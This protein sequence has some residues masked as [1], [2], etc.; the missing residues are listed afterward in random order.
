MSMMNSL[1]AFIASLGAGQS[2][3][4]D[5]NSA[6]LELRPVIGLMSS[7]EDLR[8]L[9]SGVGATLSVL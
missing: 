7:V 5:P 9:L 2:A 3:H 4:C 1:A 8:R 6:A